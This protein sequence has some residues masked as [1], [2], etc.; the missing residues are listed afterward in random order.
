MNKKNI[1]TFFFVALVFLAYFL[2]K[3]FFLK[4][5]VV[6]YELS[7]MGVLILAVF[8]FQWN[9]LK[10]N[11]MVVEN[12]YSLFSQIIAL[13]WLPFMFFLSIYDSA[14]IK[15][16]FG[17]RYFIFLDSYWIF[18]WIIL[19]N[20]YY[21]INTLY[22][23]YY[24]NYIFLQVVILFYWL[25]EEKNNLIWIKQ[26]V[27]PNL[28]WEYILG[29]FSFLSLPIIY[30]NLK[31][32]PINVFWKYYLKSYSVMV[33]VFISLNFVRHIYT[34]MWNDCKGNVIFKYSD[35]FEYFS[36]GLAFVFLI[37]S[38]MST[39]KKFAT[40]GI[41]GLDELDNFSSLVFKRIW[42]KIYF[43]IYMIFVS[44]LF[45]LNYYMNFINPYSL[46]SIVV[47]SYFLIYKIVLL[48]EN[49]NVF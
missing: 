9:F 44:L 30:F 1:Y 43:Y 49:K 3:I 25:F 40:F 42:K 35:Y 13:G 20:D 5:Q 7:T 45:F 41:S 22:N 19:F 24:L 17:D 23:I 47:F 32:T 14:L 2:Y 39:F 37:P 38:I 46:I 36:A 10:N 11:R 28:S 16:F 4:S 29:F 18:S 26:Y 12:K 31:N 34:K 21:R 6:I 15:N 33:T 8:V 48:K 27:F